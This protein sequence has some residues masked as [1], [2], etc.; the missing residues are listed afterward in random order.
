MDKNS[1]KTND[2]PD[3][4]EQERILNLAE[5]IKNLLM[6]SALLIPDL[7]LLEKV[8]DQSAGIQ[9]KVQAMAPI[10]GAV[11]ADWEKKDLEAGI[12]RRR[13]NAI[14][15]LVK[16]IKE[17]EDERAEFAKGQAGKAEARA[18]LEGILGI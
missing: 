6:F 16:V 11:G 8:A 14:V 15:A 4:E 3:P 1:P 9:S 5:Q 18:S 12:H 13:A 7:D 10:F 2:K 17:T